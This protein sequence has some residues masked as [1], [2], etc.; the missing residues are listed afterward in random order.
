MTGRAG[1]GCAHREKIAAL[2]R[3]LDEQASG[4]LH[5]VETRRD[6][7][8]AAREFEETVKRETVPMIDEA[9]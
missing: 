6:V 1:F 9:K 2:W 7:E 3:R 4:M 5:V 8:A